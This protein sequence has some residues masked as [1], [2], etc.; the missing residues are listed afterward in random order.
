MRQIKV[1]LA[2]SEGRV[3]INDVQGDTELI[4]VVVV[5]LKQHQQH[6]F[7]VSPSSNGLTCNAVCSVLRFPCFFWRVI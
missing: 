2:K 1:L 4:R 3:A 5:A 7:S 6:S